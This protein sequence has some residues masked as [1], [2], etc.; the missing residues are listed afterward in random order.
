MKVFRTIN[1][2]IVKGRTYH[3]L[4]IPTEVMEYNGWGKVK[5]V[6]LEAINDTIVIRKEAEIK[7]NQ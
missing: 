2:N 7:T 6:S 3:R 1:K 4:T 5:I